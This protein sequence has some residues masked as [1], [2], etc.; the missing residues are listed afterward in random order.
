MGK[1]AKGGQFERDTSKLLSKW[2]TDDERD[3]VFWRSSQSGGRATVRAKKGMK[4]ANSYGD[5]ACLDEIG[6]PLLNYFCLELKRGYSKDTDVLAFIDSKQKTP[7]I[8]QFWQQCE[9]DRENAESK[10]SMVIFKR[11]RKEIICVLN[12]KCLMEIATYCGRPSHQYLSYRSLNYRLVMMKLV[13]FLRWANPQAILDL[14]N[15]GC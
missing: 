15:N 10:H 5:I 2:W 9:R 8:L 11:D 3:D 4:T 6:R 7:M 14:V 12:R 1:S 13:D